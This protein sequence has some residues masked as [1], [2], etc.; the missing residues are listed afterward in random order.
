[1]AGVMGA[2]SR[3]PICE[4][5]HQSPYPASTS[6]NNINIHICN[7]QSRPIS[8]FSQTKPCQTT[9]QRNTRTTMAAND[10]IDLNIADNAINFINA[11][12]PPRGSRPYQAL[13]ARDVEEFLLL[14]EENMGR[15]DL[16]GADIRFGDGIAVF[17]QNNLE[18][19]STEVIVEMPFDLAMTKLM[20]VFN[21]I[22]EVTIVKEPKE[23]AWKEKKKGWVKRRRV[24]VC[25]AFAFSWVF[26]C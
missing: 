5:Q 12:P 21:A 26:G 13:T 22:L 10:D 17:L 19:H 18:P 7:P 25:Y 20:V 24:W 9:N 6:I 14:N 11:P 1:M 15:E 16:K 2:A 23:K 8:F 3:G 4:Y